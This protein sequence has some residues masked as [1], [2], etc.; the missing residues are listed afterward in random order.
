MSRRSF[1]TM[2]KTMKT[3]ALVL[4]GLLFASPALHAEED[5]KTLSFEPSS[6]S[7]SLQRGARD[8]MAY[9]SGCHSLKYL[10]YN[11]LGGDLGISEDLLK[12][13][14]IFNGAKVGDPITSALPAQAEQWFGRLP[15]DLT[16]ETKARGADWVYS[17]LMG[18]YLDSSRPMGVNNLFL[19]GVA[20]P[21]VLGELQGWQVKEETKGVA[22]EG[23]GLPLKLAAPGSMSPE[24]YKAFVSDLTSFMVYAAEPVA[25]DRVSTGVKVLFYLIFL[26]TPLTWFLKKEF[27]RD[28]HKEEGH[29]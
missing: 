5:A 11:R 24:E 10:R 2:T 1:E 26:L 22:G 7:A 18:F 27:W 19:P 29:H 4:S 25:A 13:N 8:F 12:Q 23:E 3:A 9:C 15:P 6:N 17:Y 14:L 28:V 20:M 16:L 21:A